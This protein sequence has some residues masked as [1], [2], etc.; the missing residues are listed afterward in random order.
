MKLSPFA[1]STIGVILLL[2]IGFL[3]PTHLTGNVID[4]EPVLKQLQQKTQ[5]DIKQ[6]QQS[7]Q[8]TA[9]P[10][11]LTILQQAQQRM[12]KNAPAWAQKASPA[13]CKLL[14]QATDANIFVNQLTPQLERSIQAVAQQVLTLTIK[15]NIIIQQGDPA[16]QQK[17]GDAQAIANAAVKPLAA[18]GAQQI[19]TNAITQCP[20]EQLPLSAAD[21]LPETRQVKRVAP[22]S[23]TTV[24]ERQS[25]QTSEGPISGGGIGATPTQGVDIKLNDVLFYYEDSRNMW[26]DKDKLEPR[27]KLM[28]SVN[29]KNAGTIAAT[30]V[31]IFVSVDGG[32]EDKKTVTKLEPGG[33]SG[34]GFLLPAGLSGGKHELTVRM[35]AKD[36]INQDNNIAKI[37]FTILMDGSLKDLTF[38]YVDERR[39]VL[40]TKVDTN[41]I[42][43]TKHLVASLF[44][45]N[46]GRT[47]I[48]QADVILTIDGKEQKNIVWNVLGRTGTGFD[49]LD[50]SPGKHDLTFTLNIKGDTNQDNNII[51]SS[52]TVVQLAQQIPTSPA[53][54]VEQPTVST[55]PVPQPTAPAKNI[56]VGF[57]DAV[58]YYKHIPNKPIDKNAIEYYYDK[59]I[60]VTVT[61]FGTE[62]VETVHVHVREDDRNFE[63]ERFM[64]SNLLPG[65]SQTRQL[66]GRDIMSSQPGKHKLAFRLKTKGDTNPANDVGV[67]DYN[68]I[69]TPEQ[70]LWPD[71]KLSFTKDKPFE[72]D[73]KPI[74]LAEAKTNKYIFGSISVKTIV[75]HEK[76]TNPVVSIKVDDKQVFKEEL[77]GFAPAEWPGST[78]RTLTFSIPPLTPGTHKFVATA[79][80]D[81]EA[82]PADNTITVDII[83]AEEK[84]VIPLV[85]EQP[86]PTTPALVQELPDIELK[87]PKEDWIEQEGKFLKPN[88]LKTGQFTGIAF[89]GTILVNNKG[90]KP[91]RNVVITTTIDGTQIDTK[92]YD[93]IGLNPPMSYGT[94]GTYQAYTY[95]FGSGTTKLWPGKHQL[96]ITATT[97]DQESNKANNEIITEIVI[98]DEKGSTQTVKPTIDIRVEK[99]TLAQWDKDKKDYTDRSFGPEGN[100]VRESIPVLLHLYLPKESP[101]FT[102]DVFIDGQQP[103]ST[104]NG[105]KTVN[106]Q[107]IYYR[108]FE[109]LTPGKHHLKIVLD[110]QNFDLETNEA[111]NVFEV[112]FW[113]KETP[114]DIAL[115]TVSTATF[116]DAGSKQKGRNILTLAIQF[117]AEGRVPATVP[118]KIQYADK[119]ETKTLTTNMPA[120]LPPGSIYWKQNLEYLEMSVDRNKFPTHIYVIVDYSEDEKKE[121]NALIVPVVISK[122]RK[123]YTIE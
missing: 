89:F 56:D 45:A 42:D 90:T 114:K 77:V 120:T 94:S 30:D 119:T 65:T 92:T 102:Y 67:V 103:K 25:Q 2:S 5:N 8:P 57:K 43:P 111:N 33:V 23:T 38:A 95:L 73:G 99:V 54:I 91:A 105:A 39:S 4:I 123:L 6:A 69:D 47:A 48:A 82:T 112:D 15:S 121:N 107:S 96:K 113:V 3:G 84:P 34:Y 109:F 53:P 28:P 75:K 110:P 27:G 116:D 66:L 13:I 32:T 36:D 24:Y 55:P 74:G 108:Q 71:L 62:P 12:D 41:A 104:S 61:N 19:L 60:D 122:D 7:L 58:F 85:V 22:A 76:S 9:H 86:K 100:I 10:A 46:E 37:P 50:L 81:K 64:A 11:Y 35:M 40:P 49:I 88:Q 87:L 118:V 14:L 78:E 70:Q 31:E 63:V 17:I 20:K 72:Q 106:G 59:T 44:V 80:A 21:T 79:T 98:A 83:V 52:I 26:V 68:I 51:K 18:Y 29:V 93:E 101:S 97:P 1:A 115:E 16:A 117:I